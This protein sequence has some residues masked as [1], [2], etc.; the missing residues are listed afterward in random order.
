MEEKAGVG[1][2]NNINS[3]VL[4]INF[5]KPVEDMSIDELKE[6]RSMLKSA[7][8]DADFSEEE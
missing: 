3:K 5:S 1:N 2:V 4:N 7:I 6:Q 8:V